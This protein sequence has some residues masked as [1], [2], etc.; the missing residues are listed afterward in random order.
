ML[1]KTTTSSLAVLELGRPRRSQQMFVLASCQADGTCKRSYAT[2]WT[3]RKYRHLKG[4]L[5]Q[6]PQHARTKEELDALLRAAN[7]ALGHGNKTRDG[8]ARC[9]DARAF[10]TGRW[11]G[12][13]SRAKLLGQEGCVIARGLVSS[14]D[15]AALLDVCKRG[16]NA[17]ALHRRDKRIAKRAISRLAGRRVLALTLTLTP[18]PNPSPCPGPSPDPDPNPRPRPNLRPNL[19]LTK[20][21]A[22]LARSRPTLCSLARPEL[23]D[24]DEAWS[25]VVRRVSDFA[26]HD[27]AASSD[28]AATVCSYG[29]ARQQLHLHSAAALAYVVARSDG[30][31]CT[32]FLQIDGQWKDVMA[33]KPAAR[34]AFLRSGWAAAAADRPR[35]ASG[36][37]LS[38]GDVLYFYTKRI[39]CAPPPP[40]AGSPRYT[41]FGAFCKQGKTDG[42][43]EVQGT[44]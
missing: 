15:C 27:V 4:W 19:T 32:Q 40:A 41:L 9:N 28:E 10:G 42:P 34:E 21:H 3:G 1:L 6:Q 38:P 7:H 8:R 37:K 11:H 43:P 44:R 13:L 31:D 22:D 33:L 26:G 5:R 25:R 35:V 2:S 39:H 23:P 16:F 29:M 30:A 12:A 14:E 18:S 36:D 24:A 20:V 17:A